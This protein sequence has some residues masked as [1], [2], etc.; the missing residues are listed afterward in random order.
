MKLIKK[1]ITLFFII[2][3]TIYCTNA[4]TISQTIEFADNQFEIKNYE[5][6]LQNYKRILFF[7]K[8]KNNFYIY[9]QIAN[10][11]LELHDYSKAVEYYKLSINC[12]TNDSLKF[13]LIFKKASCYIFESE[14]RYALI[15]LYGLSD[16]LSIYFQKRKFFYL[17]ICFYGLNNFD[18]AEKYFIK[19]MANCCA[20]QQDAI[21]ILFTNKKLKKPNPKTAYI[22]SLILPGLGQIYA[23]DIKD[24]VNSLFLTSSIA[25]LAI[26]VATQ[27]H[28]ID[29]ISIVPWYT[30]FYQGGFYNAKNIAE[31]KLQTNRNE[32]FN[33]VINE[34]DKCDC[35]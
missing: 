14:F 11:Y 33:N 5:I 20:E 21:H 16:T 29:A 22:L 13:E 31:K 12:C 35:N 23:G 9:N 10:I 8:E 34:I 4:Q 25:T 28:V 32:I 26:Y 24:G 18:S 30:R 1:Y 7:E 27:Y 15:D 6:A 19:S 17:G 3:S 2:F